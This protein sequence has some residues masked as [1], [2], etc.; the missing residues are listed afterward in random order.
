MQDSYFPFSWMCF[1]SA[2][3]TQQSFHIVFFSLFFCKNISNNFYS[4]R[5]FSHS[6]PVFVCSL[7]SIYKFAPD[8]TPPF[9]PTCHASPLLASPVLPPPL[10]LGLAFA[11]IKGNKML[12]K[13]LWLH[14]ETESDKARDQGK[15]SPSLRMHSELI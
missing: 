1:Y 2:K 15:K 12:N 13:F 8:C 6:P 3:F 9:L 5:W 14:K 10:L 11:I 4:I 7:N